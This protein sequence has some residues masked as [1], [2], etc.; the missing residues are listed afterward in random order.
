M[1][2]STSIV[3]LHFKVLKMRKLLQQIAFF[4]LLVSCSLHA[5]I[6]INEINYNPPES[7]TDKLEFIEFYNTG[8]TNLS[9]KDYSIT[10]AVNIV[11]PDT[12]IKA[13]SYFVICVNTLSFD[14]A[15]GFK[16]LQWTSG[17]LRNDSEVITLLDQNGAVVDSV[18][19]SDINGWPSLPDGFGPSLELCRSS[20]DNRMFE[21][22]KPSNQA[23]GRFIEGYELKG[24][25]GQENN[26]DCAE[27][28]IEVSNFKFDPAD[29]T[30]NVG[31]FIE[32]RNLGG[33]HNINGSKV[34][35]PANPEGFGNGTPSSSLWSYIKKFD[36][37]GEY[38]YQCDPHSN[39]MRGKITVKPNDI[40][41][42]S[43]MVGEVTS[44]NPMGVLDSLN[45]KCQLEGIVYGINY[46]V[47]GLQFT[48]I[49]N[50]GDGIGAF[51]ANRNYSYTVTEGDRLVLRGTIGQFNGLAQINLDTIIRISQNNPLNSPEV[52]ASL[53][54]NTESQL[55]KIRNVQLV[56]PVQWSNNPLGFTVKVTNGLN[57]FDVRI[58]NDCELVSKEAPSGTF[59]I[60]GLGSQNDNSSPFLD[61]YQIW[62]RNTADISPYLPASKFYKRLDIVDVKGIN[63]MGIAD[64][65]GVKCELKGTVYGIDY[66]GNSGLQFTIIDRTGGLGVF[67][68]TNNYGY[69]VTEG[70]EVI[71]QGKIDQFRGLTQITLDS[72]WKVSSGNTLNSPKNVTDLNE[73]TESDLVKLTNL[74]IVD[75]AE[76]L[77]NGTS[78]SVRLSNGIKDFVM[79]I[80]D[81]TD[82]ANT[83][84]LGNRVSVTGLGSQFDS[85]SPFDSDYLIYPRYKKDL[86]FTTSTEEEILDRTIKLNP[87][88][89]QNI[90]RFEGNVE[91]IQFIE[92]Y[93]LTGKLLLRMPFNS[94]IET[95][96]NS[97]LYLLKMI[98]DSQ[99]QSLKLIIQK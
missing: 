78:F 70:D 85:N 86:S 25:P 9:L 11:F 6:I 18:R 80:D 54:E 23:R 76:W 31:E 81:N 82:I 39:Q 20:A 44:T 30:I 73:S 38:Q 10:D 94:E 26:V 89:A 77:G 61:G 53:N 52:I 83:K 17:A 1:T 35:Y 87:Q 71:L 72:M 55:V 28:T 34:T 84:P 43:Y 63:G 96:L 58:D 97:G 49:D 37:I 50:F 48:I 65:L 13:K 93:N 47:S 91:G 62:P 15:F 42:P 36:K 29:I 99:S 27:H 14:T 41:Y 75:P 57:T 22:W 5:Q 67:S 98:G 40:Q 74:A 46:R 7:G 88:P 24:S 19:Y 95:S 8:N 12:V 4:I 64:S 2:S 16:A 79:R 90:F 51:S 60:T 59:D 45:V 56:N 68:T 69:T 92:I 32:W 21:Y 3:Y 33:M 66:N